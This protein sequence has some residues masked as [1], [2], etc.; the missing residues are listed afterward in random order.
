M[1]GSVPRFKGRRG[2]RDIVHLCATTGLPWTGY[3]G[4]RVGVALRC[5]YFAL[6]SGSSIWHFQ[7]LV[8][9][10]ARMGALCP[11]FKGRR[12]GLDIV[13]LC[14]TTGLPCTGYRGGHVGVAMRC[15][16]FT[17]LSGSSIWRFQILVSQPVRMGAP[18]PRSKGRRGG[19]DIVHLCATTGFSPH[20][21]RDKPGTAE[22]VLA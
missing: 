14:A 18:C 2:G 10:P 11:R 6:L 19:L 16:Y 1:G 4:G 13:H 15:A 9:H 8:S 21:S 3:R 5:A 22:V 20:G 12:G 17:L 7:I